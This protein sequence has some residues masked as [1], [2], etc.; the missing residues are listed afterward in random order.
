M[1]DSA[2][3]R[4]AGSIAISISVLGLAPQALCCR[5][6]RRLRKPREV[7]LEEFCGGFEKVVGSN[8]AD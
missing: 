2:A 3:A 5:L 6:L 7:L 1:G 8:D 4:C